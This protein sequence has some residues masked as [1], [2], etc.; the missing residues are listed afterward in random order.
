[1]FGVC[2]G[3]NGFQGF[4][5]RVLLLNGPALLAFCVC[6]Y[7]FRILCLFIF[8]FFLLL[9]LFF[10]LLSLFSSYFSSFFTS[11]YQ[12]H[13]RCLGSRLV[14]RGGAERDEASILVEDGRGRGCGWKM[15]GCDRGG[16]TGCQL[17]HG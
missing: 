10:L 14:D 5:V 8:I 11:F 9:L 12:K 3:S 1:M 17:I 2:L 6:V 15:E 4:V 13:L 7:A 16:W